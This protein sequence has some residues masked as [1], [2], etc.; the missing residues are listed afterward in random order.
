[1]N[2]EHRLFLGKELWQFISPGI[3]LFVDA[4]NASYG[5][6]AF[7]PR[8]LEFDAGIGLRI[9]LTRSSRNILRVDVAYTFDE[10]PMG[11]TGW[12]VSFSGEQAF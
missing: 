6:A 8:N 3:A 4:G 5:S 10:D 12:L 9:G 1:M 2:L 11:R 7:D